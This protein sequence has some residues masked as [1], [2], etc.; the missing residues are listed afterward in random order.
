MS[1]R[2]LYTT[3]NDDGVVRE[4]PIGKA[5]IFARKKKTLSADGAEIHSGHLVVNPLNRQPSIKQMVEQMNRSG[6]LYARM[7]A[8][9]N[10]KLAEDGDPTFKGYTREWLE[11]NWLSDQEAQYILDNSPEP[12]ADPTA[13]SPDPATLPAPATSTQTTVVP[14]PELGPSQTVS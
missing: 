6:E 2:A 13:V 1:N 12:I 3:H 7:L 11:E 14:S 8:A 4:Y 10:L 9:D 5:P